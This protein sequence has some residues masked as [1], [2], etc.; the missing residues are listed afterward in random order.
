MPA[1]AFGITIPFSRSR[2]PRPPQAEEPVTLGPTLDPSSRGPGL[3]GGPSRRTSRA[4]RTTG[5][6]AVRVNPLESVP[7]GA[8]VSGPVNLPSAATTV[9]NSGSGSRVDPP[10]RLPSRRAVVRD[11]ER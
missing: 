3:A 6:E 5:K 7:W 1:L 10:G 9:K 2:C 11:G 8:P 4:R